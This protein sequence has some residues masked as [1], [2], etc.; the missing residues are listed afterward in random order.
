MKGKYV[1]RVKG[2]ILEPSDVMSIAMPYEET[3]HIT[4]NNLTEAAEM[5]DKYY[6]RVDV[7]EQLGE[8]YDKNMLEG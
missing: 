6:T 5:S 4:A 8:L 1:Y 7:L 3:M 2:M